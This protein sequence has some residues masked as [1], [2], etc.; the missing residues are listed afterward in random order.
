[1]AWYGMVWHGFMCS[2]AAFGG[3]YPNCNN[4]FAY[5]CPPV[6]TTQFI[7][8]DYIV[9]DPVT[10]TRACVWMGCATHNNQKQ[11]QHQ[12]QRNR[13]RTKQ[14]ETEYLSHNAVRVNNQVKQ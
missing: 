9:I 7:V 10:R 6:T 1:M 12:Q 14:S 5:G 3:V 13:S 2:M 4:G 11:R 8:G